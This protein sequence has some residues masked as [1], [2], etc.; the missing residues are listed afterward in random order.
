MKMLVRVLPLLALVIAIVYFFIY[1]Q[2][3]EY[4]LQQI[5][6]AAEQHD[7]HKF[8]KYVDVQALSESLAKQFL[9]YNAAANSATLVEPTLQTAVKKYSGSELNQTFQTIVVDYVQNG[10]YGD[11]AETSGFSKETS[12]AAMLMQLQ[13]YIVSKLEFEG[14][15]TVDK[16]DGIAD[17]TA[18]FYMPQKGT[19]LK[20]QMKMVDRGKYWQIVEI[21]N[22]SDFLKQMQ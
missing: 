2:M 16:N 8:E 19:I 4:S 3:P 10:K 9:A 1:K 15:R 6:K 14:F 11:D 17:V 7:Q 5:K 12:P 21:A 20:L 13:D 22:L 18:D